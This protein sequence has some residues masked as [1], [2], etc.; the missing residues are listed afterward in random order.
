MDKY[1]LAELIHSKECRYN[2]IDQCGWMYE[3]DPNY[4]ETKWQSGWAHKD[5][6]AKTEKLINKLQMDV[7][8]IAKVIE[9]L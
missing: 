5:Y 7:N 6:L 4:T 9:A 3:N 8:D 1:E 2:H